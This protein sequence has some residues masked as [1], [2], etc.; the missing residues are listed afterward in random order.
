MCPSQT[1]FGIVFPVSPPLWLFM[2]EKKE[3]SYL[4]TVD[5]YLGPRGT[6]NPLGGEIMCPVV[7][8][9]WSL[10]WMWLWFVDLWYSTILVPHKKTVVRLYWSRTG[11][12]TTNG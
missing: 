3:R 12:R 7:W 9:Y 8:S 11:H 2:V 10:V 5:C 4:E 1:L 6:G